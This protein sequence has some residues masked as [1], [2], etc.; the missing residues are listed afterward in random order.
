[1]TQKN[2][3]QIT[4]HR[5]PHRDDLEEA[6]LGHVAHLE[7][8]F[9]RIHGCRVVIEPREGH[10][11]Q[12]YHVKIHVHVPQK[13]LVVGQHP[14]KPGHEDPFTAL[15]DAFKAIGRQLQDYAAQRRGQVKH[16]ETF[17]EAE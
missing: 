17:E 7:K 10:R 12:R 14:P 11:D 6:A 3:T 8:F 16:H 13:E 2:P 4:F 9:D 15:G 5:M 1:M